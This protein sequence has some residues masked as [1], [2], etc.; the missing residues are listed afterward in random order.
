MLD[1]RQFPPYLSTVQRARLLNQLT[2]FNETWTVGQLFVGHPHVAVSAHIR[3]RTFHLLQA[4]IIRIFDEA[5]FPEQR[6]AH[7]PTY[8]LL[9]T[10]NPRVSPLPKPQLPS[11]H[12]LAPWVH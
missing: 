3:T 5:V 8:Y 2:V 1:I 10:V 9:P 11:H 7:V 4:E 12:H 6:F